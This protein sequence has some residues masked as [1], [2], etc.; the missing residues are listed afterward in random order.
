MKVN[1]TLYYTAL[2]YC[3]IVQCT[4]QSLPLHCTTVLYY[5]MYNVIHCNILLH[6]ATLYYTIMLQNDIIKQYTASIQYV[7]LLTVLQ[8]IIVQCN[9][10]C[11][12]LYLM[13]CHLAALQS[14][15]V[16]RENY[17]QCHI[18]TEI[19]DESKL[20]ILQAVVLIQMKRIQTRYLE[21]KS[22]SHNHNHILLPQHLHAVNPLFCIRFHIPAGLLSYAQ[23]PSAPTVG[24]TFNQ[25]G[26]KESV[27]QC[28]GRKEMIENLIN[29]MYTSS[30]SYLQVFRGN[31]RS[32]HQLNETFGE[33][34][35]KKN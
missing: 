17:E 6:T 35:R 16:K 4:Q 32:F 24:L 7:T 34:M 18:V 13:T 26:T 9:C 5:C 3:C 31:C 22:I 25:Y 27:K 12:Q 15:L 1:T 10:H 8:C 14:L 23:H 29:S 2:L 33:F 19:S 28:V 21:G 30:Y 11:V 20:W